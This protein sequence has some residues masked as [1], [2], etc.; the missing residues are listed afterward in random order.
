MS[1]SPRT[2]AISRDEIRAVYAKGEDAVIALV[3]GLLARIVVLEERV[4]K[5]ENQQSKHSGNSSK[6]PSSDGFKPKPKSLRSKSERRSG[7][8]TGHPG[9]T[10]EWSEEVEQVERHSVKA[11]TQCGA[12]LTDVE[13]ESWELRQVRDLAPIRV[14]VTEH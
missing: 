9:Q 7:G 2:P 8:Q 5:L 1:N 6:P 10:L 4:E 11:C 14:T 12:S 3:E 13:V